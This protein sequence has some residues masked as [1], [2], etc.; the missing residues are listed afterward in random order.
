MAIFLISEKAIHD[1]FDDLMN[2]SECTSKAHFAI[3]FLHA[4][5]AISMA[6]IVNALHELLVGVSRPKFLRTAIGIDIEAHIHNRAL[7]LGNEAVQV[8]YSSVWTQRNALAEYFYRT[9]QTFAG[10]TPQQA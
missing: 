7:R 1:A 10:S 3:V 5:G 2:T 8:P 9:C 4:V 6:P